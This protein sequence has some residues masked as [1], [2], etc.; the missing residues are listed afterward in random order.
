MQKKL[1]NSLKRQLKTLKQRQN[2]N[3]IATMQRIKIKRPAR[4]K[5]GREV[6]ART[7]QHFQVVDLL[8]LILGHRGARWKRLE[9]RLWK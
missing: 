5:R 3:K 6:V 9:L 7:I 1:Q 4:K 2:D 8:I